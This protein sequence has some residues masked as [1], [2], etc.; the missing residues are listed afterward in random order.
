[1]RRALLVLALAG[2]CS[3]GGGELAVPTHPSVAPSA[4]AP[5]RTRWASE[6]TVTTAAPTTTTVPVRPVGSPRASRRAPGAGTPTSAR[7][8][9][10][11]TG[12]VWGALGR[13]ESGNNPQAVGGGGRYFGAFQFT[14][15][16]WR[17]GG[18]TG[19]PLDHDYAT[20]LR[21]AQQLQAKRGWGQWPHC[22]R[23]LGLI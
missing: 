18:G 15:A 14:P 7:G 13:C 5:D 22:A 21:V 1:M 9:I 3:S 16:A 17:D 2:A 11:A 19:H 23:R 10:Q 4:G 8:P 20:Q 6:A 12:D